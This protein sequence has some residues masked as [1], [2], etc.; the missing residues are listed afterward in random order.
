M[1]IGIG[2][3]VLRMRLHRLPT[4]I[5]ISTFPRHF[6]DA[7]DRL[8]HKFI[9]PEFTEDIAER[10]AHAVES[11]K[12]VF[13]ANERSHVQRRTRLCEIKTRKPSLSDPKSEELNLKDTLKENRDSF[14]SANLMTA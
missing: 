10:E 3:R 13:S 2:I 7:F 1:N 12:L 6:K 9:S 14:Y 4:Q 8:L 5:T 11:E